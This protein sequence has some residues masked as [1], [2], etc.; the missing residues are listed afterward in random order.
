MVREGK[1]EKRK[2]EKRKREDVS[3]HMCPSG[4]APGLCSNH[5][6]KPCY[7]HKPTQIKCH[8]PTH[9]HMV[10]HMAAGVSAAQ[11]A[12]TFIKLCIPASLSARE[13][14]VMSFLCILS[15]PSLHTRKIVYIESIYSDR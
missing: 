13:R 12:C 5:E 6:V 14:V 3:Y 4:R 15:I 2:G 7:T 8:T 10:T 11:C 1:T 9:F